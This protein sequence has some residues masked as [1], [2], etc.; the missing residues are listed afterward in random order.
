MTLF[1][2]LGILPFQPALLQEK[3]ISYFA[4]GEKFQQM[5][6]L[7]VFLFSDCTLAGRRIPDIVLHLLTVIQPGSNLILTH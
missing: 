7:T 3:G 1:L 6:L 5:A 2:E 4:F